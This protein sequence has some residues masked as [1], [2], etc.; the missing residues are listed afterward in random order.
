MQTFE[1]SLSHRQVL[2]HSSIPS[3]YSDLRNQYKIVPRTAEK[4]N[5]RQIDALLQSELTR[6]G[7][8]Y[9]LRDG[10]EHYIKLYNNPDPVRIM[11]QKGAN[12]RVLDEIGYSTRT[13]ARMC[14]F[15]EVFQALEEF[16][17]PNGPSECNEMKQND[18]VGDRIR[19]L[20]G[21]SS[22]LSFSS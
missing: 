14:G 2:L 18:A 7:K 12:R 11:C 5:L 9:I 4:P 13:V 19:R 3:A 16:P 15:D 10:L 21:I 1:C 22:Y 20:M 6:C 8:L 17:D